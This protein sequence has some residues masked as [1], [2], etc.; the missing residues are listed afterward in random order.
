M[1]SW[2]ATTAVNK[3]SV[4]KHAAASEMLASLIARAFESL[5]ILISFIIFHLA[6]PVP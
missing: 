2:S 3:P 4:K 5:G 1:V 6:L